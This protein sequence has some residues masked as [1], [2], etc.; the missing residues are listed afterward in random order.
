MQLMEAAA[1]AKVPRFAF[2]SVHDYGLP[3]EI[4]AAKYSS[5]IRLTDEY[6]IILRGNGITVSEPLSY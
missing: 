6:F 1:A 2:I 4:L 3:G 5:K